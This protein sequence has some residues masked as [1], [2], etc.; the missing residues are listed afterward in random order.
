MEGKNLGLV[1][2]VFACFANRLEI[3]NQ[4]PRSHWSQVPN[5]L[6]GINIQMIWHQQ[7]HSKTTNILNFGST[8]IS[9][10]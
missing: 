3:L 7:G 2:L 9:K 10:S 4:N 8:Y 6:F 5:N 1:P